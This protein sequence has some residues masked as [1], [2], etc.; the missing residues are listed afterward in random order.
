MPCEAR[1]LIDGFTTSQGQ[2]EQEAAAHQ[3]AL[4]S[5]LRFEDHA[6]PRA[7]TPADVAEM[8]QLLIQSRAE[9][10]A[11]Q[12]EMRF[13]ADKAEEMSEQLL[14]N[15]S[16]IQRLLARTGRLDANRHAFKCLATACLVILEADARLASLWTMH[17]WAAVLNARKRADWA[18]RLISQR[19]AR[20]GLF[21]WGRHAHAQMQERLERLAETEDRKYFEAALWGFRTWWHGANHSRTEQHAHGGLQLWRSGIQD[22]KRAKELLAKG[23]FKTRIRLMSKGFRRWFS[24]RE[25]AAQMQME[26]ERAR[27]EALVMGLGAQHDTMKREMHWVQDDA[28]TTME[29]VSESIYICIQA[30]PYA[31]LHSPLSPAVPFHLILTPL[32]GAPGSARDDAGAGERQCYARRGVGCEGAPREGASYDVH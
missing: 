14:A 10:S 16:Q 28:S 18:Q 1:A 23:R 27:L 29:A 20:W 15:E 8:E 9:G 30:P 3:R 12:D 17:H 31:V 11:A 24:S 7:Y 22:L 19:R 21:R 26:G 13:H 5:S 6:G 2:A 4:S 32:A 25:M